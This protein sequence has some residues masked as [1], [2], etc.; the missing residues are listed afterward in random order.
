M[1][2]K[3]KNE[4]TKSTQSISAAK[5]SFKVTHE[6][7]EYSE[8]I[9]DTVRE[10]LLAL[11]QDL[12]VV[13]ASRS[14]YDFFK[15]TSKET[16]GTLIYDLGNHQWNIPKLRELLETILPEKTTFDNYEV[17]HDFSTIGKRIM[18]LNARQIERAFG[19]KK[20]ILLAIE[21]ITERKESEEEIKKRNEQLIKLNAEK[22][23]FFSIIAHDL[24]SPFNWFLG[25]TELMADDTEEFSIA[26]YIE[27]SK[28]LNKGAQ[29]LYK[30]LENLLEWAQ[31]KKGSIIFTPAYTD[32]S[33]IV[34]RSIITIYAQA[35]QK[36][37]EILNKADIAKKVY[38]DEKMI[39]TVL[40]NLLSNAIKFT[41]T[42]GKV[43]VKTTDS[44]NGT[45]EVSVEDSGVGL[46]EKDIK[47]LFK[48]EEK[49]SSLGTDGETS[50]GLGLLLCKEFVEKHEGKIW[51]E[52]EKNV[53]STFHFTLPKVNAIQKGKLDHEK[54]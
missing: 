39:G 3:D 29:K 34:S 20:I 33:E 11:D 21:D 42:D 54:D 38:V 51:V 10:P 27:N 45:I 35:Q 26:E 19:K 16:I 32:L 6:I 31:I 44:N 8:N 28:S 12:R 22:D 2:K 43:I 40:R 47:R 5:K 52:S 36:G 18:L 9:I 30:L 37:I 23:I 53:G 41:K 48:I 46:P 50:S 4:K 7:S 49:V 25:L 15:V 1:A 14:F 13:K 17:E 24:R